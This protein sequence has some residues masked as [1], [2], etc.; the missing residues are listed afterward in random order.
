MKCSKCGNEILPGQAFCT[1]CGTPVSQ[2]QNEAKSEVKNQNLRQDFIPPKKKS[3]MPVWAILLILI[4]VIV[5]VVGICII[6]ITLVN[7]DD[8][9]GSSKK[10]HSSNDIAN[11]TTNSVTNNITNNT[12]PNNKDKKNKKVISVNDGFVAKIPEDYKYKMSTEGVSITDKDETM[13]INLQVKE[14]P[15]S[16]VV[17]RKDELANI[18][19]NGGSTI[20]KMEEKVI[21]GTSCLVY[22]VSVTGYNSIIA[23]VKIDASNTAIVEV[24]DADYTTYNYS[25]LEKAVEI[26][27]TAEKS[28]DS[29]TTTPDGNNTITNLES[30]SSINY[31]TL[32]D[33]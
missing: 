29:K 9:S 21:N 33:E 23:L 28:T 17:A 31:S 26:A 15:Y 14:H 27:V 3:G 4:L 22:E 25:N 10:K 13:L 32:L 19:R 20:S 6:V 5:I 30:K 12:I 16:T 2:M 8:D 7:A 24:I 18:L 1:T 11:E